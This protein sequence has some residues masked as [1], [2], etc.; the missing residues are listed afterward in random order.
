MLDN[1]EIWELSPTDSFMRQIR[2]QYFDLTGHYGSDNEIKYWYTG[3]Y[4]DNY[5]YSP[6][7]EDNPSA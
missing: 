2:A 1:K 3:V 5:P 6:Q 7:T 4:N